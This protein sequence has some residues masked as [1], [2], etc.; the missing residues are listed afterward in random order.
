MQK[1]KVILI[2]GLPGWGLTNG[3]WESALDTSI[4]PGNLS[5]LTANPSP[6]ASHHDR[7]CEVF[8]QLTGTVVDYGQEHSKS[9]KHS[10]WGN[11]YSGKSALFP[12]WGSSSP[13]HFICHSGAVNTVR[14]LQKLL[15]IDFWNRRTSA[16]WIL[17]VTSINGA[18]N[19]S[20]LSEVINREVIHLVSR[21]FFCEQCKNQGCSFCLGIR[22]QKAAK[23]LC[24]S[25]IWAATSKLKLD[26]DQIRLALNWPTDH[27]IHD[28]S[29]DKESISNEGVVNRLKSSLKCGMFS[30]GD[31][32][33]YDQTLEGINKLEEFFSSSSTVGHPLERSPKFVYDK[34]FYLC[35]FSSATTSSTLCIP[36][37]MSPILWPFSAI[38]LDKNRSE[39]LE[40]STKIV[41]QK[42]QS[43]SDSVDPIR[44]NDGMVTVI[45]QCVPRGAESLVEVFPE[46][47]G[48]TSKN[49]NLRP[50]VWYID[51]VNKW[52]DGTEEVACRSEAGCESTGV[53]VV[54]G[55][56][57]RKILWDHFDA[58]WSRTLLKPPQDQVPLDFQRSLYRNL[59]LYISSV[60]MLFESSL[61]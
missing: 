21:N 48:W 54:S 28:D 11:D 37:E 49:A 51:I 10:R 24:R 6:V 12:E 31:N 38:L 33:I 18:L 34:T 19:E 55:N 57:K 20:A 60:Q 42:I 40:E 30:S 52:I 13:V 53:D 43:I 39:R 3:Y 2:P 56:Q 5:I 14:V 15:E 22:V 23:I 61:K 32:I 16:E 59:F 27:W 9:F 29:D 8:A 58:C 41:I 1:G 50:G 4:C 46:K 25:V 17:S 35:L 7:A 45:N 44:D 47:A 36:P 26:L